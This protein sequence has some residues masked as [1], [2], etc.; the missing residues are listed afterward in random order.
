MLAGNLTKTQAS[1]MDFIDILRNQH[2]IGLAK[3]AQKHVAD[4]SATRRFL[5]QATPLP[6]RKQIVL[7]FFALPWFK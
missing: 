4:L 2:L 6:S 1:A 5:R 3:R 7:S